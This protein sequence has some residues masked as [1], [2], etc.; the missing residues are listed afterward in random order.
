MK[1]ILGKIRRAVADYDM[2]PANE[3][4]CVAVSGGKDSMLMLK[5]MALYSRFSPIPFSVHAISLDLGF[6][7]MDYGGMREF[8]KTI[9]VPLT[10]KET[11]IGAIVFEH[12]KEKNPCALCSNMKRGALHNLALE[13]G[14]HTV[15][16]GHHADDQAETFL[17]SLLYEGR[18]H[19]FQ[20][21][22][23]LDRKKITVI[24]PMIYIREKEI[25]Y[26]T[27]KQNIPVLKSNCPVDGNTKRAE[28]K[29]LIKQ[30]QAQIPDSDERMIHAV[31]TFLTP[32]DKTQTNKSN[33][34]NHE[35]C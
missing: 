26:E 21:V 15:A 12:R 9:G 31:R 20:P 1:S 23:Y 18:M 28:M 6:G 5:A 30:L 7:N 25:I 10:V 33:E 24:R 16:L 14:S 3:T 35:L 29:Q 27:N 11:K 8:C 19:T 22:T 13:L 2:I 17:L 34:E 32:A 4:V